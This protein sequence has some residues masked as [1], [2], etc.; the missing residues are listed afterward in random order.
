MFVKSADGVTKTV[1]IAI[2]QF[3]TRRACKLFVLLTFLFR[4]ERGEHLIPQSPRPLFQGRRSLMAPREF[5]GNVTHD[6]FSMLS[7]R[8]Q[9]SDHLGEAVYVHRLKVIGLH[10]V[11]QRDAGRL[12]R[13]HV[14]NC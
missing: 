10:S 11:Q 3:Q 8:A 4:V 7:Q 13:L 1:Y 6:L 2:E 9:P 5:V 12:S 14:A